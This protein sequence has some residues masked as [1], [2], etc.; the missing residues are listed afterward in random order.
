MTSSTPYKPGFLKKALCLVLAVVWATVSLPAQDLRFQRYS[1]EDGLS[2]AGTYYKESILQDKEGFLWFTTFNGLNRFDG[3]TFKIFQFD[4]NNPESLADN[5][6]TSICEADD[7]KIWVISGGNG[8]SIFDPET[9]KFEHIKHDP[10]DPNSLCS[11]LLN[12]VNKDL[13]G[14]MWLGVR[15][16]NV[17]FWSQQTGKFSPIQSQI[18][19]ANVFFQQNNG[20]IWIGD[21]KGIHKK[22]AGKLEFRHIPFPE[23]FNS[24]EFSRT[25]DICEIPEEKLL[26]TTGMKGFWEFD[27]ANETFRDMRKFSRSDQVPFSFLKDNKGYVWMGF[28][29]EMRKFDPSTETLK[30]LTSNQDDPASLPVHKATFGIQDKAGNLWF[31]EAGSGIFMASTPNN[32]FKILG[33]ISANIILPI[34]ERRFVLNTNEGL[35]VFD[36]TTGAIGNWV[37]PQEFLEMISYSIELSGNNELWAMDLKTKKT[38]TFN[39][40]SGEIND[41]PGY[42]AK[43]KADFNGRIWNALQYYDEANGKWIDMMPEFKAA[44]PNFIDQAGRSEDFYSNNNHSIWVGSDAGLF[45]YDFISKKGKHYHHIP[46]QPSSLAS[47]VVHLMYAGKEGRF[48]IWTTNGMSIYDPITD[49]FKNYYEGNGLLHNAIQ[50][51][52]EDDNGNP[53]IGTKKGLQMLDVETGQF[54]NYTTI[55]GL[56]YDYAAYHWSAKDIDGNI[57]MIFGDKLVQFHPDSILKRTV[58]TPIYLLD[59]FLERKIVRVNDE[60][61]LFQNQLRFTKNIALKYNQADFGFSFV[62]PDFYKSKEIEYFFRLVPYQQDWQNNRTSN[63]IHYTNMNP[64]DYT[65]EVKAKSASGIW[66]NNIASVQINISPP[67]WKTWWAYLLYVLT[68]LAI[69]IG[70]RNYELRRKLAQAEAHRLQELDSLKTRLYTNITHEFRTPLTVIMGMADNLKEHQQERNLIRRNSKNLLRLINQ[71]LDLSKLDSGS[72]KMDIVQGDIINY[73]KYLTES[74]YSMAEEK[75]I[76]LTFYSEINELVMDFDEVKVQHIIYNLLSN[77]LKF[78]PADGQVVLNTRQIKQNGQAYLQIKVSDTGIGMAP[79]DQKHIFDRFYQ[80]DVSSTRKGEGTGI[81]LA[82]TKE[83]VKMMGGTIQVKSQLGEGTHFIILLPIVKGLHTPHLDGELES[84]EAAVKVYVPNV[85]ES[86]AESGAEGVI[87]PADKPQL[88]L[89]EDNKDVA[90]YIQNL[91]KIEY[92][93]TIAKDGQEGIDKALRIIPDIIISDVMMPKKDGYEVCHTLKTDEL[94]SH[95]PIILLTAKAQQEDKVSGLKAGADAYLMKPFDKK[96]LF[97]RLEKLV[98]LR[99]ALQEK[100]SGIEAVTQPAVKPKEPTLEDIFL[101]KVRDAIEEHIDDS[102]LSIAMICSKLHVS[103]MQL[104]RKLKA[105]TGKTPTLFIRSY[106]LNKALNLLKTTQ[107]NVSEIAY[108]TG[109]SDPAYFSRTFKEEFGKAPSD[110]RN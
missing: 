54:I 12:F 76:K 29:G 58:T 104:Y 14:N 42:I 3:R 73:L 109:F 87:A 26:L 31:N 50:T 83:L 45:Y 90:T 11:N 35:R 24:Y 48:Y 70:I 55:D 107:L 21:S 18:S 34:G 95:I 40:D 78:T 52:I 97:V 89:V 49:S 74:F 105:L 63:E 32:A 36:A 61:T 66:S 110:I 30:I 108:D 9:E 38:K 8:L 62:M 86:I 82:L 57:Y 47:D 71:L 67:W 106:R 17:C 27:A 96:E 7:G 23:G 28:Q 60:N 41:I 16:G 59:F 77:A 46:N 102:E 69:L 20:T 81:G 2:D 25:I 33:N 44:F 68:I 93:V 37:L 43:L 13:D 91:L 65:F 39:F 99:K 4:S 94:T 84:D 88:L 1:M 100:Y 22:I 80:A 79:E 98:E 85:S 53:W 64:G 101:Q 51:L 5:L 6:C 15:F 19:D 92:H 10:K 75:K 103:N 56:P 72:M